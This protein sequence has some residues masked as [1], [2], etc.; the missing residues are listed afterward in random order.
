MENYPLI[1]DIQRSSFVDGPGIRTVVFFKGCP[2]HCDW[3]HNPE[4]QSVK[5][6]MFWYKNLCTGCNDCLTAC[7]NN[8]IHAGNDQYKIDRS[9]CNSCGDCAKAC[10]HS[11]LKIAGQAY[12]VESLVNIILKD[13]TYFNTSGGGVTFSGGEPLMFMD[14]LA[15]V[16]KKLKDENINIAVQTCGYFNFDQFEETVSPYIN[17]IYFDLKLIDNTLHNQYT[18]KGNNL[19]LENLQKLFSPKKHKIIIRTPLIPGI[20]DTIEN[21]GNI[22]KIISKLNHNGYEKL[23][24]NDS[25]HKKA[26]ALGRIN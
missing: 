10:N 12:S 5:S 21:L 15:P 11:A 8:A 4:S 2:L 25:F 22:S 18:G 20:T 16:C 26:V 17:T 3:C 6:E 19:I 9:K 7:K 24:F 23:I 13:K 1:Y 14:F